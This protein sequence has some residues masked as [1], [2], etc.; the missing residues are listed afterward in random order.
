MI[1]FRQFLQERTVRSEDIDS[2]EAKIRT[3]CN[4]E[5]FWL[6][7][8]TLNPNIIGLQLIVVGKKKQ[9]NGSGT[10]AMN[11]LCDFADSHSLTIALSPSERSAHTGTTSK[12]R[13]VQFYQRFGFVKNTGRNKHPGVSATMYRAPNR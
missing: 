9:G 11:M 5:K 8:S 3:E 10:K 4:L 7:Q 6:Y 12:A 13:L 2:I 1:T